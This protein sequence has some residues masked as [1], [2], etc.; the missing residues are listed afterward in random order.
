MIRCHVDGIPLRVEEFHIHPAK[1]S[2][3]ANEQLCV[4]QI[5]SQAVAAAFGKTDEVFR[6]RLFGVGALR[7]VKPAVGREGLAARKYALIVVLNIASQA[8]GNARRNGVRAEFDGGARYARESL[9]N[10]V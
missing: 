3:Q 7:A 5:H 4:S 10:P 1:E 9:R 2:C 6:E 8:D